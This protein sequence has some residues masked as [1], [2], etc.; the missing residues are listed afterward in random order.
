[1]IR[2][3][4]PSIEEDDLQAVREVLASGYLVQGPRVAAFE[5]ALGQYL[6]IEHVVAVSSGTAALHLA[7]L[8]VGVAVGDIVLTT[9]Y[10][11]PAT[12]NVIELC[13]ATPVFV[14]IDRHTFNMDPACLEAALSRLRADPD[15]APRIKAILPVHAFGQVA[16]MPA[17]L[18][19]ARTH[20]IPVVEDAACALGATWDGKQAGTWGRIGCFSL[21]PRKAIT[22][23]EGGFICTSDAAIA[24]RLRTLRN[25]GLD[26][27]QPGEFVEPGFNYRM[28][29][30]QAALGTTQLAKLERILAAR[31]R[32]AARYDEL[33][34]RGPVTPPRVR[35]ECVPTYQ[36][37]VC[38]LPAQ[39]A[40]RR[41]DLIAALK[42]RGVETTIGTIHIPL[43]RYYSRAY[44]Y[45][46][47][48]FSTTDEVAARSLSL[49]LYEGI[50]EDQQQEVVRALRLV[51]ASSDPA[52]RLESNRTSSLSQPIRRVLFL[53]S[54]AQGLR[55][56][57]LMHDVGGHAIVGAITIDDRDD[58]R[59]EFAGFQTLCRDRNLPLHVATSRQHSEAL[60]RD[61][62]PE[63]CVVVGWYW[64]IGKATLAAVPHGFIGIHNS[65]LPK[66]RG[67]SPLVWA[68]INGEPEVGISMFSFSEGIDDGELWAQ[69][70]VSVEPDEYVA[71]VL[72]KLTDKTLELL[73]DTFPAI[74]AGRARPRPQA[75]IEP[76]YCA[77]RRPI[78]GRIDWHAPAQQVHDFIRAQSKP[79]PGAFT[80]FQGRKLIIWRARLA[81][82]TY[83]GTPGQVAQVGPETVTVICGDHRPILLEEVEY[84]GRTVDAPVTIRSIK[85]RFSRW[86]D[87]PESA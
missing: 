65:L 4:I 56:L 32:L 34:C 58:T 1:M 54:K 45:K 76:T 31:R 19:L 10:S 48:D 74:L 20:A 53:G 44:G 81:P 5:A 36:T 57:S 72:Q 40:E 47:G 39:A 29:E 79:Y 52:R 43:T 41:G 15:K 26:P 85:T 12:A 78:D 13:G 70:A 59:T 25:H 11:W 30:F 83:Y 69:A 16:D 37:Y 80:Y 51:V 87:G 62:A 66:Y 63:L 21:H 33:L 82:V 67:V 27:E 50:S 6:R 22:T 73:R 68:M 46:P 60:A 24:R 35:D 14:D 2:L 84:D 23:G 17:I 7:L 49:P 77:A 64:L 86:P 28:T 9:A 18:D 3:T 75:N 55:C 8:A 38:L 42:E 71:D 61:L